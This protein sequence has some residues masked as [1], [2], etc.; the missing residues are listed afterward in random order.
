VLYVDNG[1]IITGAGTAAGVDTLLHLVRREWGRGRQRVG[2]RDGRAAAP[3]RRA[4]A[5]HR[6]PGRR[7]EDDLLG[8]VLEWAQGHLAATSASRCSPAA[9]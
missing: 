5:V 6:R 4:G 1:R 8:A 7:V 9:R 3:R 2:A